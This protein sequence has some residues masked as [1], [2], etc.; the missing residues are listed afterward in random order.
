MVLKYLARNSATVLCAAFS[1]SAPPFLPY[2]SLVRS[3]FRY[4]VIGK[5]KGM[6]FFVI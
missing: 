4:T 5:I 3:F 6:L 2:V 1:L